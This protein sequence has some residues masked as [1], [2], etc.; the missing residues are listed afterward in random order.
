MKC[1]KCETK[2]CNQGKDCAHIN[3]W[4]K[5]S[6]AQGKFQD[7]MKAAR[8]GEH[9]KLNPTRLEQIV[10]LSV[11]MGFERL[12]VAFCIGLGEEAAWL[13]RILEELDLFQVTSVCCKVGGLYHEDMFP[14]EPTYPGA[15]C[16]CNPLGLAH[17]LNE[18]QTELN[19]ALGLC[20]GHDI[21]FDMNTKAPTTTLIVKDN[22]LAHNPAA[23]FYNIQYRE[24]CL[25]MRRRYNLK[26]K[27]QQ[28]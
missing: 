23:V 21:I 12:G 17:V 24:Q 4:S 2:D 19:I 5:A 8:F 18:A 20:V 27:D 3:D 6:Y 16:R 11:N 10:L 7:L 1:A 13:H 14:G 26:G 25:A 22:A 9:W 15:S 28:P